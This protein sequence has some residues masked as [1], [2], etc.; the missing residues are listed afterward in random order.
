M[1]TLIDATQKETTIY[2][3]Q[4]SCETLICQCHETILRLLSTAAMASTRWRIRELYFLTTYIVL[5]P[6]CH[7]LFLLIIASACFGLSSWP[8]S[9]ST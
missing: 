1:Q 5:I 4:H 2:Q 3:Q 8:S 6:T 7:T 9:E